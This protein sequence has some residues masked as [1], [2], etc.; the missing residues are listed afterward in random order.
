[1]M[2]VKEIVNRLLEEVDVSLFGKKRSWN[3]GLSKT[4]MIKEKRDEEGDGGSETMRRCFG[5]EMKNWNEMI[6]HHFHQGHH[7]LDEIRMDDLEWWR[8]RN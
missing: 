2:V 5:T 4:L 7:R 3:G 8:G 1:M 6:H